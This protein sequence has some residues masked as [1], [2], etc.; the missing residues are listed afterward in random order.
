M[1][2]NLMSDIQTEYRQKIL[3]LIFFSTGKFSRAR[4]VHGNH[5]ITDR[6]TTATSDRPHQNILTML[7]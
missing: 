4:L 6:S 5:G 7:L 3:T 1:I 2:K